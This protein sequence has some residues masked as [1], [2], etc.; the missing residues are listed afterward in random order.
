MSRY[1]RYTIQGELTT[2]EIS[3]VAGESGGVLV[4]V[5]QGEGTTE[6]I[7]SVPEVPQLS[8]ASRLGTG[9]EVTEDEVRSAER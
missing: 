9:V 5:K 3:R 6:L 4:R 1:F 8:P 2:A 7:L